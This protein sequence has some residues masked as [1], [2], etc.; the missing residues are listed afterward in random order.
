MNKQSLIAGYYPK[1]DNQKISEILEMFSLDAIY[2]RA[3]IT[4]RGIDEISDFFINKRKIRG[5]HIL[6]RVV[7]CEEHHIVIVTGHFV[8]TGA[9]GDSRKVDFVDIWQFNESNKVNKRKTYLAL[10]YEY[11][12]R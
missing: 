10:G 1:I 7:P 3:D 2:E 6:D 11:V 5:N 4:Y 9:E 8:G 12:E